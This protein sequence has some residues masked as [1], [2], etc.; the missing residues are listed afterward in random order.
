MKSVVL[1]T[2]ASTG[3]GHLSARALAAAG[4]TVYASMRDVAGR[5]AARVR[6]LRDWSFAQGLDLR[7]VELDVLSQASADQAV[8]T[9][10]AEQGR[11]DAVVHNAGHLVV[12]PTEAFTP[13]EIVKVFDTNL[14]GTQRVN[15][16]V[17]PLLRAQQAG[18]LLWVSSTTTRGGFPPF[19]G[20]YAAAKAAMDSLAVTLAYEVARFGIETSLVV[21]GAFTQGTQHFPNAGKPADTATVAAYDARYDGLMDQVGARLSAL[22]PDAAD[23][24]AVADEIARIVSL[25]AGERPFRSVIDFLDDG[26]AAVTEVAERVREEFAHRIGIADL[27]KPTVNAA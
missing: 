11:L 25:P 6:E 17:L 12:G 16:A 14:L 18:L 26:A 22:M 24:Q 27:L 5:N 7:T 1:V 2:G 23:P 20:P 13:E 19:L 15:K 8:Q 10:V 4:H 9:I 3:I 21:P